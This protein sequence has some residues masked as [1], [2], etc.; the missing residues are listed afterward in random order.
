MNI[1]ITHINQLQDAVQA[2]VTFAEGQR[3]FI[4]QAEMG[5]GK[6]TFVK[7]FAQYV[8]VTDDT[9]SPTYS[10]VNEYSFDDNT[11]KGLIRHLDLYRLRYLDEALDIGIEDFFY[12]DSFLFIEW[13]ELLA[14]ILP[15]D[16]IL[17]KIEVLNDNSRA[18]TFKK[19][20]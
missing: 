16:V 19:L 12:D 10:L 17:I 11:K 6:T 9:S 4:L 7:K 8:G 20:K 13:P 18:F 5:S 15:K 3:K 2:L 14:S 1:I